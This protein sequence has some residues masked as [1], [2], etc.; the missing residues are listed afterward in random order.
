MDALVLLVW[1]APIAI[2]VAIARNRGHQ[3]RARSATVELVVDEFGVR[4][5]LADGREEAVDWSE[6]REVTLVHTRKGPHGPAGGM[7]VLY[8]DATRGCVVPLDRAE[9]SGLL[10]ALSRLPGFDVRQ[11]SNALRETSGTQEL[12]VHPEGGYAVPEALLDDE[13]P[14]EGS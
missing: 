13:S 12:W 5:S 1:I 6:V 8:G 9:P 7:I 4:R 11:L 14:D 2:V 10:E 3:R